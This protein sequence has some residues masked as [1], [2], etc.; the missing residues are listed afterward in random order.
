[1][2]LQILGGLEG[3]FEELTVYN[4]PGW[5]QWHF[6]NVEMLSLKVAWLPLLQ[7]K[8]AITKIVL[9][10]GDI[11]RK[12]DPQRRLTFADHAEA[13]ADATNISLALPLQPFRQPSLISGLAC[14]LRAKGP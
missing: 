4:P 8:I 6:L 10:N 7:R 13:S 5:Q 9:S 11:V 14:G 1:V 12:H 2:R 3:G